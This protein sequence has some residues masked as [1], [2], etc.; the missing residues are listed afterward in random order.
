MNNNKDNS[1]NADNDDDYHYVDAITILSPPRCSPSPLPKPE[2]NASA[3]QGR[4]ARA[5]PPPPARAS[6]SHA[7]P[8]ITPGRR[9]IGRP[10]EGGHT[11][12]QSSGVVIG[13]EANLL[14]KPSP[15]RVTDGGQIGAQR[16]TSD[17][18]RACAAM[19][20]FVFCFYAR[21]VVMY[22]HYI[23]LIVDGI[24]VLSC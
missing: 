7:R 9:G 1:N 13:S 5:P 3:S 11:R 20:F 8:Y 6:S 21:E 10:K 18:R 15:R 2:T 4:V 14:V 19:V 12:P 24:Y 17:E 16:E 22:C 23:S